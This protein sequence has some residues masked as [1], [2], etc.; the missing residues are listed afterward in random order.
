[1]RLKVL[2]RVTAMLIA[3]LLFFGTSASPVLEVTAVGGTA[4]TGYD[5]K[6]NQGT[7][8][9][10]D[11]HFHIV[12]DS[13]SGYIQ[14]DNNNCF[15]FCIYAPIK[16]ENGIDTKEKLGTLVRRSNTTAERLDYYFPADLMKQLDSL[17]EN[18]MVEYKI[19]DFEYSGKGEFKLAD[20]K[21]SESKSVNVSIEKEKNNDLADRCKGC[22]SGYTKDY[23]GENHPAVL[24]NSQNNQNDFND[25]K[26]EY[27]WKENLEYSEKVPEI[28]NA[29]NYTCWVKL[30]RGYSEVKFTIDSCISKKNSYAKFEKDSL[31]VVYLSDNKVINKVS[32]VDENLIKTDDLDITYSISDV[33]PQY[34]TINKYNGE[35]TIGNITEIQNVTVYANVKVKGDENQNFEELNLSYSLSIASKNL[36]S[37]N[38][39]WSVNNSDV[40]SNSISQAYLE[41]LSYTCEL[42]SIN[43]S[44]FPAGDVKYFIE[45]QQRDGNDVSDVATINSETGKITVKAAGEFKVR[46]VP[47]K[48]KYTY[49]DDGIPRL[50][51]TIN[52]LERPDEIK[53]SSSMGSELEYGKNLEGSLE[54][55]PNG[56]EY[57]VEVVEGPAKVKNY[58]SGKFILTP[59]GV[60][61]VK[62]KATIPGDGTYKETIIEKVI[63]IVKNKGNITL[64]AGTAEIADSGTVNVNV[65]KAV[66][67]LN[68]SLECENNSTDYEVT[69]EENE[70]SVVDS[71]TVADNELKITFKQNMLGTS[72]ITVKK[73]GNELYDEASIQ[74][75]VTVECGKITSGY[76]IDGEKVN[77]EWYTSDVTVRYNKSNPYKISTS[78]SGEWS[79]SITFAEGEHNIPAIYYKNLYGFVYKEQDLLPVIK[80]DNTPPEDINVAI[81]GFVIIGEYFGDKFE[82]SYYSNNTKTDMKIYTKDNLSGINTISYSVNGGIDYIPIDTNDCLVRKDGSVYVS[83]HLICEDDSTLINGPIYIKVVDKAGLETVCRSEKDIIIDRKK[84]QYDDYSI[85]HISDS[86]TAVRFTAYFT[87]D[88]FIDPIKY[89]ID[90][91]ELIGND[92]SVNIENYDV[93]IAD[94]KLAVSFN[95]ENPGQY[96][97]KIN[98]SDACGNT[99]SWYDEN[100]VVEIL[101]QPTD[102]NLTVS[103]DGSANADIFNSVPDAVLSFNAQYVNFDYFEVECDV[104]N[105]KDQNIEN[106]VAK[107]IKAYLSE[108]SNWTFSNGKYSINL[109]HCFSADGIYNITVKY[110]N[111]Y[112]RNQD[113]L[114][115]VSKSFTVDRQGPTELNYKIDNTIAQ[116]ILNTLFPYFSKKDIKITF[117][118]EDDISGIDHYEYTVDGKDYRKVDG[119]VILK[120]PLR[121]TFNFRVYDKA[122][123]VSYLKDPNVGEF[124]KIIIDNEPPL[125]TVDFGTDT[126]ALPVFE[127]KAT[128]IVTVKETNYDPNGLAVSLKQKNNPQSN[129]FRDITVA[130]GELPSEQSDIHKFSFTCEDYGEYQFSVTCTDRAGNPSSEKTVSFKVINNKDKTDG[131]DNVFSIERSSE[132]APTINNA[133]SDNVFANII[134]KSDSDNNYFDPSLIEVICELSDVPDG[135]NAEEKGKLLS[136]EFTKK[137]QNA[138]SWI[139][140]PNKVWQ[141]KEINK[142]KFTESAKYKVTV[143]YNGKL[144]CTDEFI[145]DTDDPVISNI[146]FIGGDKMRIQGETYIFFNKDQKECVE[147]D[148]FDATAGI[149]DIRYKLNDSQ[150]IHHLE[151]K[152]NSRYSI[153]IPDNYTGTLLI[154]VIDKANRNTDIEFSEILVKDSKNPDI[155]VCLNDSPNKDDTVKYFNCDVD[156]KVTIEEK[157]FFAGLVDIKIE[158]KTGDNWEQIKNI[159]NSYSKSLEK[160]NVYDNFQSFTEPGEYRYTINCK[161]YSG[162]KAEE[163]KGHFVI[164][165]AAPQVKILYE[166][167]DE[168]TEYINQNQ[169]AIITV[170]EDNLLLSEDGTVKNSII[171]LETKSY[172]NDGTIVSDAKDL[173]NTLKFTK[174]NGVYTAIFPLEVED[175]S[176]TYFEIEAKFKDLAGWEGRGSESV[177]IDKEKPEVAIDYSDLTKSEAAEDY[178][179]K[180]GNIDISITDA[181]LKTLKDEQTGKQII[182][183]SNKSVVRVTVER[184][185]YN[186]DGT[187]DTVTDNCESLVFYADDSKANTYKATYDNSATNEV[188]NYKNC[189]VTVNVYIKDMAGNDATK[190]ETVFVDEEAPVID[191]AYNN[192][193]ESGAT[194]KYYDSHG[195]MAISITDVNLKTVTDEETE[196][197]VIDM[198]AANVTV[199]K[200][201]YNNDGSSITVTDECEDIKFF[202]DDAMQHTYTATYPLTMINVEDTESEKYRNCDVSVSV[203]IH[204]KADN[205]SSKKDSITI[206][207]EKPAVSVS[208]D[209]DSCTNETK[210]KQNHNHVVKATVTVKDANMNFNNGKLVDCLFELKM[211]GYNNADKKVNLKNAEAFITPTFEYSE[212]TNEYVAVV[213]FYPETNEEINVDYELSITVEDL[214][215]NKAV[216]GET[217][218]E[219]IVEK[220]TIDKEAPSIS[221]KSA[222]GSNDGKAVFYNSNQTLNFVITDAHLDTER[223][224]LTVKKRPDDSTA[225]VESDDF[226]LELIK[227]KNAKNVY[228][229]VVEFT[230]SAD[231][232]VS[233]N[234]T[235]FAG[236]TAKSPYETKFTIDKVPPKVTVKFDNNSVRNNK[237]FRAGRT[238]TVVVTEKHFDPSNGA[239]L[240]V[241]ATDNNG[242]VVAEYPKVL[243]EWKKNGNTYTAQIKF[244]KDAN[245]RF[246]LSCRDLAG[247]GNTGIDYNGSAAP[248]EFVVD[249][250]NPSGSITVGNWEADKELRNDYSY[251]QFSNQP[252]TITLVNSDSLS[253]VE[254]VEYLITSLTLNASQLSKQSNWIKCKNNRYEF[255]LSPNNKFIVYMHV[256]DKAGNEKYISSNGI[257]LDNVEPESEMTAPVIT[258]SSGRDSSSN[259]FNSDVPIDVKVVDPSVKGVYSGIDR[260]SYEVINMGNVTSQGELYNANKPLIQEYEKSSAI[261]VDSSSNNSNDVTVRVTAT[262][263]A[264]NTSSKDYAIAIDITDPDIRLSYNNND[265]QNEKY[266]K[267]PRTAIIEVRERNFSPDDFELKIKNEYGSVP[268]IGSWSKTDGSGNGDDTVWTATV[269]FADDGDYSVDMS[270]VDEAGNNSKFTAEGTAPLSFVI[271][272]TRPRLAVSYN[273]NSARNGNYFASDRIAT[274]T[275]NERNFS[276][277]DVKASVSAEINGVSMSAPS[278][279]SWIN[280]GD[281]HSST[282]E[283]NKDGDYKF[284][285]AYTDLAGNQMEMYTPDEF[286][287]DK[288]KAK[289]SITGV[290]NNTSY[291]GKVAPVIKITDNNFSRKNT[292]VTLTG[293]DRGVVQDLSSMVSEKSLGN[294]V[295]ISFKNFEE[296]KEFDDIYT[297]VVSHS[298][299][300][301]NKTTSQVTFSVNRFGSTYEF[302]NATTELNNKYVK[303]PNDIVITEVNVAELKKHSVTIYRDGVAI[304]LKE[305]RDYIFEK[306]SDGSNWYKYVYTIFASNFEKDGIYSIKISSVDEAGNV[307]ENTLDTKVKDLTFAVDNTPPEVFVTN[308]KSGETYPVTSLNAIISASDNIQIS[309][310]IV[311]MDGEKVKEWDEKQ[312]NDLI[313]SHKDFNYEIS[314]DSTAAHNMKIVCTDKAGNST[315][316]ELERFYVTTNVAVRFFTNKIMLFSTVAGL[317]ILI[318]VVVLV[319]I[320][321]KKHKYDI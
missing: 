185:Y 193:D 34:M 177:T 310:L 311:Y 161:D 168:D 49:S 233:L 24:L 80:V 27:S 192:M 228:N 44:S 40:E 55:L 190:T 303:N 118:A 97:V 163:R 211:N 131:G 121:A 5:A 290:E 229:A 162:N 126:D 246:S 72:S 288:T 315:E 242:K 270:T 17:D 37:D 255:T 264:G 22:F 284:N 178:Y 198:S 271:D 19:V 207:E 221:V 41:G 11:Y 116:T 58:N 135:V 258:V 187:V 230:E 149:S 316:V 156:M 200:K 214:A 317:M 307:A 267:D 276:S 201:Y 68:L 252:Q 123:N 60:G 289:I 107:D 146:G 141:L 224:Q 69:V 188:E 87:D 319:I 42:K 313:L 65:G 199:T 175:G 79:D 173:T 295:E 81:D 77:D 23:D 3:F 14:S 64:K 82:H 157:N 275:I 133:Y 239:V 53:F 243:T 302:N 285:I 216:D 166:G 15:M 240:D 94:N 74:F 109:N 139:W 266:F 134:L 30:T 111:N 167:I 305:G 78:Y 298:D 286:H 314:G 222:I 282:I 212:D 6:V 176:N 278:L 274:V 181:N 152:G 179:K 213:D 186:N 43:G 13:G 145:V 247:N 232:E 50:S 89:T 96:G 70:N 52:K 219:K 137:V 59:T 183:M 124:D 253:G 208:Y 297:L 217:D 83:T 260:V 296:K 36:N 108:S 251:N 98:L 257:I 67:G 227:D 236:N 280:S 151:N 170:V 61:T 33:S 235:D 268:S 85:A 106:S 172:K 142:F 99:L 174:S 309:S 119:D 231:Y 308:V 86:N 261:V 140:M 138:S 63:T 100:V 205:H 54:G 153:E 158:K 304:V 29:G 293:A 20:L 281:S 273:N 127:D 46:A 294:G 95:V 8:E 259:L 62:I 191:I 92:S 51:F 115:T 38:V 203:S 132:K 209:T 225:F 91:I 241:T 104:K 147:F 283:Y 73:A 125:V 160:E 150:G 128:V 256:I 57:N 18:V 12:N 21:N 272:M 26:I 90:S 32:S 292:T 234:V 144:K 218:K 312:V 56:A 103:R 171:S 66:N 169:T 223:C 45:E 263:Y 320:S 75:Y 9:L 148:A 110:K 1:M 88:C 101:D 244:A 155:S 279:G 195:S 318:A 71:A 130:M 93:T 226:K 7:P 114:S 238:A 165:K 117:F 10:S 250:N 143:K 196:K 2:K 136:E 154:T 112:D 122:G 249:T 28:K 35:I 197:E 300:A 129:S 105:L 113:D 164:D 16:N 84:P 120:A 25:V 301:G 31:D 159:S 182:D 4:D 254:S 48:T 248:K 202:V 245:Y 215:G 210:D 204:D 306:V 189:T 184:K 47:D 269:E 206:D 287:I 291:S 321:R 76:I 220:F 180:N 194:P 237:Y 102:Y 39:K 262:D 265:A 277:E 299:L